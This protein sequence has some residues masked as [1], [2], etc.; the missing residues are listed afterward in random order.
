M[1]VEKRI[2]GEKGELVMKTTKGNQT[3]MN[4]GG[5]ESRELKT[6]ARKV[7]KREYINRKDLREN[8]EKNCV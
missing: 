4:G 2:G 3:E 8:R 1:R 5:K 7:K 6:A